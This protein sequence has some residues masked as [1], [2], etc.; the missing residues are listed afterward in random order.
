MP[1][2]LRG[3]V[4]GGRQIPCDIW[5][6]SRGAFSL[7]SR[8][9]NKW[10]FNYFIGDQRTAV[11]KWNINSRVRVSRDCSTRFVFRRSR[12]E[13]APCA[14]GMAE[15]AG[16]LQAAKEAQAGERTFKI[17][18]L[19]NSR[20]NWRLK[21]TGRD[22]NFFLIVIGWQWPDD[23]LLNTDWV[24]DIVSSIDL[25]TFIILSL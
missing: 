22:E 25:N 4:R 15:G 21:G 8:S 14:G 12:A 19:P 18:L 7:T 23:R 6:L 13:V 17:L 3:W 20:R 9:K 24:L 11:V 2:S 1:C 5:E 16:T 10:K